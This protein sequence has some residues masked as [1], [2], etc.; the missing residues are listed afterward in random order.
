VGHTAPDRQ[1]SAAGQLP[2]RRRGAPDEPGHGV[3][4]EA[5]DVKE[6]ERGPLRSAGESRSTTTDSAWRTSS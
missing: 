1:A 6:D 4:G 3:E 2:A 5:E